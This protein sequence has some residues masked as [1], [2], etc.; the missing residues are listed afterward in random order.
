MCGKLKCGWSPLLLLVLWRE[1]GD[2][3]WGGSVI[4]IPKSKLVVAPFGGNQYE[5]L[6]WS[7]LVCPLWLLDHILRPNKGC[8]KTSTWLGLNMGFCKALVNG[9]I[10]C[11][12]SSFKQG[13]WSMVWAGHQRLSFWLCP[14]AR[15]L[16]NDGVNQQAQLGDELLGIYMCGMRAIEWSLSNAAYVTSETL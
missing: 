11:A 15:F 7:L 6:L 4:Y 14:V 9:R 5:T 3:I 12:N 8:W 10:F 1:N 2:S 16:D 13:P